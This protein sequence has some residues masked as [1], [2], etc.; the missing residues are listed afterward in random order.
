MSQVIR[1][2]RGSSAQEIRTLLL[3]LLSSFTRATPCLSS[4]VSEFTNSLNS[5][6]VIL[7]GGK[8]PLFVFILWSIPIGVIRAGVP[9]FPLT[10]TT[11]RPKRP[12]NLTPDEKV[13]ILSERGSPVA[14]VF[15]F[16]ENIASLQPNASCRRTSLDE[17]SS[18]GFDWRQSNKFH[19]FEKQMKSAVKTANVLNHYFLTAPNDTEID[20]LFFY[21]LVKANVESDPSLSSSS[22]VL[23]SDSGDFFVPFVYRGND[24][25]IRSRNSASWFLDRWPGNDWFWVLENGNYS[26]LFEQ[27]GN[28]SDLVVTTEDGYWSAPYIDC[29]ITTNW[30]VT[31]GVPFFTRTVDELYFK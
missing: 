5:V 3:H 9:P 16:I 8:T 11:A 2:R 7:M 15:Q 14:A 27:V 13:R 20:A 18:Q 26:E 10:Q 31:Y 23:A 22:I 1:F 29:N 30:H 4:P 12:E 17:F 28:G 24:G 19:S 6:I 21:S 25:K